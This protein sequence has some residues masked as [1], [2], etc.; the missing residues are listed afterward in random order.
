[1][2]AKNAAGLRN[3]PIPQEFFKKSGPQQVLFAAGQHAS[4]FGMKPTSRPIAV[5]NLA[6]IKSV[7]GSKSSNFATLRQ[8]RALSCAIYL[9]HL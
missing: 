5:P 6:P 3:G 9:L 7:I 2:S 8:G 4:S 1:L